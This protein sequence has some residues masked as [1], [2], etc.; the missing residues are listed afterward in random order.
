[1]LTESQLELLFTEW[2]MEYGEPATS[3]RG[4]EYWRVPSDS[5]PRRNMLNIL[6]QILTSKH[7]YTKED[8]LMTT[9]KNRII[10]ECFWA[11]GM[12]KDQ[13]ERKIGA[14]NSDY[15][16][17]IKLFFNNPEEEKLKPT[18]TTFVRDTITEYAAAEPDYGTP[19]VQKLD[20]EAESRRTGIALPT[21]VEDED[22][23]KLLEGSSDE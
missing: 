1:M 18:E 3:K 20:P 19:E 11:D 2:K 12:T 7:G 17:V 10:S 21:A 14:I 9:V 4:T 23:M 5:G 15:L 22:F 16:I 6:F 13:K 8:L